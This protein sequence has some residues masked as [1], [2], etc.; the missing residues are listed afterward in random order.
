MSNWMF[1]VLGIL[2]GWLIEWIIDWIYWRKKGGKDTGKAMKDVLQAVDGI[3]PVISQK[4]YDAGINTF[5]DLGALK[6]D[7]LEGIVGESIKNLAD[8]AELIAEA[9]KF[10]K[11]K[12]EVNK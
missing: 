12:K 11:I 1:L 3:G 8:E 2:I 9:K 4:L 6:P 5:E 7:D 10:A